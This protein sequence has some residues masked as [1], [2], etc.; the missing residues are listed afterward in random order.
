[1]G[2][3]RFKN[4]NTFLRVAREKCLTMSYNIVMRTFDHYVVCTTVNAQ[5]QKV[6]RGWSS[7]LRRY[8]WENWVWPMRIS[9]SS[10]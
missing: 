5:S 7:R 4:S 1:M 8:E 2:F 3:N 6:H 10:V 9:L